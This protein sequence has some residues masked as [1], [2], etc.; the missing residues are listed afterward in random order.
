MIRNCSPASVEH[1]IRKQRISKF[2]LGPKSYTHQIFLNSSI[3]FIHKLS[4]NSNPIAS[5]VPFAQNYS[6]D[7]NLNRSQTNGNPISRLNFTWR[8]SPIPAVKRNSESNSFIYFGAGSTQ[9]LPI[10][11]WP[12]SSEHRSSHTFIELNYS[13]V[14]EGPGPVQT[15]RNSC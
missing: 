1:Y 10:N 15:S 7:F 11:S 8:P 9:T 3:S 14:P 5:E 6:F 2:F 4:S 12:A 13:T